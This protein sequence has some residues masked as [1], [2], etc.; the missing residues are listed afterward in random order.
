MV[1]KDL[2]FP[3]LKDRPYFFTNFV[4]TVDGKV[5]VSKFGYW[6]I[7]SNMDYETFTFL[8]A[9]ADAIIDGKNT[10]LQFGKNTIDTINKSSFKNLR[11]KLGKKGAVQYFVVTK[12][13]NQQLEK[14]LKNSYGFKPTIFS[15]TIKELVQFLK[16]EN[17]RLVFIDGGPRLLGSFLKEDFLDEIF[18]TIAPKI[19]GSDGSVLTMV[20]G[21][22]L[23]PEKIKNLKLLSV[24]SSESE[25]YLRYKILK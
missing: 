4:S 12:N 21:H 2:T 23:P 3:Q 9:H 5:T 15:G 22:L 24:Q 17:V 7:G 18:V 16:K 25:V 14:A 20:E 11:K 13:P 19:F 8:R 6:P 10:A 1:Y